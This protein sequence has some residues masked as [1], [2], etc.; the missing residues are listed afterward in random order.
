MGLSTYTNRARREAQVRDHIPY[1]AHVAEHVVR[2]VAG[3]YVQSFRVGGVSFEAAD[4]VDINV[5]HARLN[6]LLR[7]IASPHV[8]IWTHVIRRHLAIQPAR[9]SDGGFAQRLHDRYAERV[10]HD[11]LMA[12]E[13]Y[14]SIVY[15]PMAGRTTGLAARLLSKSDR[16]GAALEQTDSL[17]H[18]AHL[19]QTVV[20]Q[21]SAY[22]A[23]ALGVV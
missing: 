12:N 4:N 15:R 9:Y 1:T 11:S 19:R 16:Q 2:T 21:L 18:C 5:R 3:D 22:E 23:E 14:L 7:T 6:V 17:D 13:L 20:E 10:A 8:A